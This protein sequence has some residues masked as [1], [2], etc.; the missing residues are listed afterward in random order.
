M[1][2]VH[3]YIYIYIG[4]PQAKTTKDIYTNKEHTAHNNAPSSPPK[5]IRKKEESTTI[6]VVV[7]CR[8]VDN[9]LFD[10]LHRADT[11]LDPARKYSLEALK[12]R[13]SMLMT[14]QS[15]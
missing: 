15:V 7:R 5:K 2:T 14:V 9:F 6:H 8:G 13:V 11:C 1:P 3:A 4:S 10:D 12:G